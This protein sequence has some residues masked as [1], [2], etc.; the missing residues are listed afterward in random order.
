MVKGMEVMSMS[1]M[2]VVGRFFVIAGLMMP[3]RLFMVLCRVLVVF[4]RLAVVFCCCLR[5]CDP[6]F[7]GREPST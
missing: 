2:G 1:H 6:P 3:R 5:H 7:L 4:R